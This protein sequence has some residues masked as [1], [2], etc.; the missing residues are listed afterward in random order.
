M[1]EDDDGTM[2]VGTEDGRLFHGRDGRFEPYAS[3][4]N[5]GSAVSA[6]LRDRD[7]NLWIGTTGN[8]ALRLAADTP[9]WLDMRDRTS[10]DVRALLED[11]EGSLWL[12]T[13]G[14]GLER[15]HNGKFIPYGPAEGLPGNL[16]WSVAP[17][18]DGSLWLGTDAGLTHYANGKFEYLAPRLGLKDVRVRAVLEDRSGTVWFG[19]QGRGLY[20]LQAG[21]LTRFAF[22]CQQQQ[23]VDRPRRLI[24]YPLQQAHILIRQQGVMIPVEGD[25][26]QLHLIGGHREDCRRLD[27]R[28]A[29]GLIEGRILLH[30]AVEQ[31]GLIPLTQVAQ[32]IL[33]GCPRKAGG[34]GV[35]FGLHD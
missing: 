30:R 10:N 12:G 28:R 23:A 9:S 24:D 4:Q 16:A 5:L 32:D 1:L 25:T 33:I 8:G 14:A 35:T 27:T 11:P 6:I 3:A 17:S 22:L 2:W 34:G 21:K 31:G 26:A 19:T 15:L 20:R 7:G 13:F 29:E 18:R